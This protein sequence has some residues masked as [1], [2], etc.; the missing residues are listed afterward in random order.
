MINNLTD[1]DGESDLQ[2][3]CN[4]VPPKRWKRCVHHQCIWVEWSLKIIGSSR[5]ECE[6]KQQLSCQ[7]ILAFVIWKSCGVAFKWHVAVN[8][9]IDMHSLESQVWPPGR[10]QMSAASVS[11]DIP[12]PIHTDGSLAGMSTQ[13]KLNHLI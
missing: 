9:S 5:L 6:K 8:N 3:A 2:I 13:K 11:H 7:T 12:G 1:S 10:H 4:P